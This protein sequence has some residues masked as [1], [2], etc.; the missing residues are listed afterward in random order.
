MSSLRN[1]NLA[2]ITTQAALIKLD[3]DLLA[4]T[5]SHVLTYA[6]SHT[7]VGG[8]AAEAKT[9]TGLLSTD[10]VMVML[11]VKGATPRTILTAAPTTDTLTVTFSGDP[12][13]DH[14]LMYFVFR[15]A[16]L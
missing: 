9:I 4:L 10:L 8:S 2:T 13:T 16:T 11:K 3:A 7:T 12:S 1:L 5:P 6:G 15:A 14:Q